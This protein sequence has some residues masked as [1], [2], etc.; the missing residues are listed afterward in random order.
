MKLGKSVS[1]EVFHSGYN[2]ILRLMD[3]LIVI[4]VSNPL[5]DILDDLMYDSVTRSVGLLIRNRI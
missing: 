1:G 4:S 5:Y 3:E 2:E